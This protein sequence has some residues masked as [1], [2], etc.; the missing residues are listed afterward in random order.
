[1]GKNKKRKRKITKAPQGGY[2]RFLK[3]VYNSL[4]LFN[5]DYM[6]KDVSVSNKRLMHRAYIR[7][8]SPLAGNDHISPKELREISEKTKKYYHERSYHINDI[9]ISCHQ[10]HVLNAFISVQANEIKKKA[11]SE[12]HPEALSAKE[13][14]ENVFNN[15]LN[16][17]EMCYFRA[18]TQLSNPDQKLYGMQM[19][20]APMR[21][22]DPKL[23]LITKIFGIP[24]RKCMMN[25]DG[26][27]RPAFQLGNPSASEPLEWVSLNRGLF[28]KYYK[29]NK[30]ELDVYIQS[31][32]LRRLRE[33]LDL[34]D[35]EAINYALWENTCNIESFV[36][37]RGY[38]LL[39]FQ[40]F[41]VK[42]G[43][44]AAKIIDDKLLFRTFLF[45][46]HTSTPE[47]DRLKELTGLAK[48]DMSYWRI[49]R[50]STFVKLDEEKYPELLMLFKEAGMEDLLQLKTKDFN[51]DDMQVANL[52]G[53]VDYLRTGRQNEVPSVQEWEVFVNKIGLDIDDQMGNRILPPINAQVGS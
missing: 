42:I 25:I 5:L 33:R 14:A 30:D 40:I 26:H 39:P 10:F 50:L 35:Q 45:I 41:D 13:S 28:G 31:H 36:I 43:Y 8:K 21:D 2:K 51:I 46:T 6:Y 12:D 27:K 20:F 48:E 38:L 37:Y 53:L 17:Y 24:A 1:M 7:L 47:G 15:F 44:L 18:M 23:E 4:L 3:D 19:D 52:D 34:L 16:L 9:P 49:D 32:A 22:D 11:G 29:G